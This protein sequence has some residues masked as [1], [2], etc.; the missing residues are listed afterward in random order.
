MKDSKNT[1]GRIKKTTVKGN[2]NKQDS[3]NEVD[4]SSI[5]GIKM[6]EDISGSSKPGSAIKPD[7]LRE[8][9]PGLAK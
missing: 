1:K 2:Q 7:M 3:E 6:E 9:H 5:T 8:D 4:R